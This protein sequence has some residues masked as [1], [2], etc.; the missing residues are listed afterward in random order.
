M[1]RNT[2]LALVTTVTLGAAAVAGMVAGMAAGT[3][4]GATA[5]SSP[6]MPVPAMA[7]AWSAAGFT[8]PTVQRC[9]GSTSATDCA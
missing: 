9:A 1:L 8:R 4:V 7:A 2:I 3:A 5:R 6:S